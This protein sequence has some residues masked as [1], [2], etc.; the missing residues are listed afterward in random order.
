LYLAARWSLFSDDDNDD[1]GSVSG[2]PVVAQTPETIWMM[3]VLMAEA[4]FVKG[5][6]SVSANEI[7]RG[8]ICPIP[9]ILTDSRKSETISEA[10]GLDVVESDGDCS[11]GEWSP[12]RSPFYHPNL[13]ISIDWVWAGSIYLSSFESWRPFEGLFT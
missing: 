5:G 7:A 12:T 9:L 6:S 13:R 3:M 8:F 4:S 2:E 10:G 11:R 1:D